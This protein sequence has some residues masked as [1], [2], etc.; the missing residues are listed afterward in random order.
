M[1]AD[2]IRKL[3][4]K[5]IRYLKQLMAISIPVA[6]LIVAGSPVCVNNLPRFVRALF[7]RHMAIRRD[8]ATIRAVH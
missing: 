7:S 2:Q 4:P 5:L 8:W 6:P 3:K 1:D